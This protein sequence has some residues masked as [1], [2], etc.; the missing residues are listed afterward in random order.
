MLTLISPLMLLIV[1]EVGRVFLLIAYICAN[2]SDII[3]QR[4]NR[5]RFLKAYKILSRNR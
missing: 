3:I 4:Y 5:P 1:Q 2:L